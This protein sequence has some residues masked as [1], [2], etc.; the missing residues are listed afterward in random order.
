MAWRKRR[1]G[2]ATH[3]TVRRGN[4]FKRIASFVLVAPIREWGSGW[5]V[6]WP[7][8]RTALLPDRRRLVGTSILACLV[9][10]GGLLIPTS[11]S[12]QL[13]FTTYQYGTSTVTTVTGIRGDNMTGNLLGREFRRR[14]RRLLFRLVR[15][16]P[17][18]RSRRRPPACPTFPARSAARPTGRASARRPASCASAAATRPPLEPGRSRLSLRRRRRARGAA[19][20]AVLSAA[21]A[22]STYARAQHLRQSGRRQL[23]HHARDRQRL[24]L[25]HPDRDLHHQQQARRAEHHGLRRLWQQDRRRLRRLPTLRTAT[26]T[27]RTPQPS[28]PT[29]RRAPWSPISRASPAPAAPTPST[30]SPI[31]STRAASRTPGRFTSTR[32]DRDLDGNRG[33]WRER[34]LGEFDLPEQADRR[35]CTERRDPRLRHHGPGHLRSGTNTTNLPSPARPARRRITGAGDD[36]A[37]SG[38]ISRPARAASGI[39]SGTYGVVTNTGTVTATGAAARRC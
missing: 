39:N 22:T 35:L 8:V 32:R 23:R 29:M 14:H 15:P 3:P 31:R 27:I 4:R 16:A 26:S 5:L 30:W 33:T 20:D 24:H 36:V 28:R 21:A 6:L 11:A 7:L 17:S 38:S 10:P 9:L 13:Q 18:R 25:R 19:H 34:D 1:D 37:N 12:A 2:A